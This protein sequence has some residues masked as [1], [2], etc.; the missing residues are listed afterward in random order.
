MTAGSLRLPA[1]S[2]GAAVSH[3]S[4]VIGIGA[5]GFSPPDPSHTTWHAG[6][7]QAVQKVEVTPQASASRGYRNSLVVEHD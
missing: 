1:E 4:A 3:N 2:L 7:H 5:A 6:P